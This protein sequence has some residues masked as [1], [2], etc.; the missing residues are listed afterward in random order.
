VEEAVKFSDTP[1][2]HIATWRAAADIDTD[3]TIPSGAIGEAAPT[4]WGDFVS[5]GG[6]HD[7][8][9]QSNQ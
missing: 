4:V 8:L 7:Y 1:L 2:K 6:F 9:S 3:T 5:S